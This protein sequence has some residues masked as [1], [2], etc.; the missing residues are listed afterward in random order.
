M[1]SRPSPRRKK[2]LAALVNGKPIYWSDFATNPDFQVQYARAKESGKPTDPLTARYFQAVLFNAINR[3]LVVQA[4]DA[5]GYV[6]PQS[7]LDAKVDFGVK[8]FAGDKNAFVENLRKN[9]S[10]LEQFTEFNRRSEVYAHMFILNVDE[11]TQQYLK[12]HPAVLPAGAT[13]K[14]IN[15]AHNAI[16][17]TESTKLMNDYLDR[18]RA[19]ATIQTFGLATDATTENASAPQLTFRMLGKP[20]LLSDDSQQKIIRQMTASFN[21]S[22][23]SSGPYASPI[24]DPN[25]NDSPQQIEATGSFLHILYPNGLLMNTSAGS[26][27]ARDLYIG[28]APGQSRL[29]GHGGWGCL[30]TTDQHIYFFAGTHPHQVTSDDLLSN[31]DITSQL[32]KAG[33]AKVVPTASASAVPANPQFY[34]GATT[35]ATGDKAFARLGFTLVEIDEKAYQQ[36]AK[37]VD[38]AVR[39]GNLHFFDQQAGAYIAPSAQI[40]F[41]KNRDWYHGWY[42][43]GQVQSLIGSA[44]YEKINGQLNTSLY[45]NAIFIG[46]NADFFLT[47]S[48]VDGI[49]VSSTWVD[50]EPLSPSAQKYNSAVPTGDLPKTLDLNPKMHVAEFQDPAWKIEPG[51]IHAFWVGRTLGQFK[52]T[53]QFQDHSHAS[54]DDMIKS[55]SPSRLAVFITALPAGDPAPT[56]PSST[57]TSSSLAP[58]D[59]ALPLNANLSSMPT[60][61]ALNPSPSSPAPISPIATAIVSTTAQPPVASPTATNLEQLKKDLLAAELDANARL[62]IY[63]KIRELPEDQF[64]SALSD[65]GRSDP[66]TTSLEKIIVDHERSLQNLMNTG[67]TPD[68]PKVK[69]LQAQIDHLLSQLSQAV[70]GLRRAMGVDLQMSDSRVTLLQNQLGAAGGNNTTPAPSGK[71]ATPQVR[72]ELKVSEIDDDVYLAN[73]D[74]IDTALKKGGVGNHRN[75]Q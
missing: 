36:N 57:S 68:Q 67:A 27:Q 17:Q 70:E 46:I 22:N 59:P 8:G 30:V 62:V 66:T 18:L 34:Q 50:T 56:Q 65:L 21:I 53:L 51:K 33:I 45:A 28:L 41:P 60:N 39:T 43:T 26:L 5:S 6:V 73:K 61:L 14:Q 2:S 72:I 49:S 35:V 54:F 29:K 12:D 24:T 75:A 37:A 4:G 47:T 9:G 23:E 38:E 10:S 64:L 32:I 40:A 31:P 25:E 11:P 44:K 55:Q 58:A 71:P 63:D 48:P 1:P 13:P 3:E 52:R 16:Y 42:S 19:K 20:V 69:A 74:K 15:D 7:K